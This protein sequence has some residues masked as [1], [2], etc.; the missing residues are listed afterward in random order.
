MYVWRNNNSKLESI[1]F[2]FTKTAAEKNVWWQSQQKANSQTEPNLNVEKT[3]LFCFVLKSNDSPHK[4]KIDDTHTKNTN[5]DRRKEKIL[6]AY[7]ACE[8]SDQ[9]WTDIDSVERESRR[10]LTT[11]QKP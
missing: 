8:S 3:I 5:H 4:A 2:I 7:T 9:V 11:K 6:R 1:V 10:E